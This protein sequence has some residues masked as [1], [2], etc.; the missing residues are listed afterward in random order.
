MLALLA[1]AAALM[2]PARPLAPESWMRDEDYPMRSLQTA[3][4]GY[5]F[6][7]IT[8]SPTGQ[9]LHCDPIFPSALAT[10]MCKILLDRARF[11]PARDSQGTPT[12]GVYQHL[13]TFRIPGTTAPRRPSRAM[14]DLTVDRLPDGIADPS[15]VRVHLLVDGNGH[16]L[17][18]QPIRHEQAQP[19]RV[20]A[21][22]G[23]TA[24]DQ[25]GATTLP[26]ARDEAGKAVES[27]QNAIVRFTA[28]RG[29]D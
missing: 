26:I 22:L 7:N 1:L 10:A 18:C 9:P 20:T 29:K 23:P 4:R 21:L 11:E 17:T 19:E 13:V 8:T 6:V 5:V 14:L 12:Y 25:L 3:E 15:T 28:R 16:S 24:C 27:V 2:T